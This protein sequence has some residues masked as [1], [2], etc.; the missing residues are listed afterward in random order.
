GDTVVDV[1]AHI[2]LYTLKAAQAVGPTGTVLAFEPSASNY[3]LLEKNVREN[4]YH[5][6][7]L[8]QVAVSNRAGTS[9]LL[10]SPV[11]TGDNCLTDDALD[12]PSEKVATVT[13]DE[14]LIDRRPSVIKM[15]I[16]GAE[17]AALEGAKRTIASTDGLALFT[18]ISP[19]HMRPW[20]GV[21]HYVDALADVG[22]QFFE[23][24]EN[25]RKIVPLP[26]SELRTFSAES[27]AVHRNLLCIKGSRELKRIQSYLSD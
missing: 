16:Q 8:A 22:F 26:A 14:T 23:I 7:Q 25:Q 11:N 5:N 15:D 9:S 1:G 12:L 19:A 21:A 24:L 18:E 13:L 20:G 6:V 27:T 2:G 10:L 3:R 17:P 4:G